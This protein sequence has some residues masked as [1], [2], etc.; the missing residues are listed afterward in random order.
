MFKLENT[1][2]LKN[3]LL[4]FGLST[5]LATSAVA[6]T[7]ESSVDGAVKYPIKDGK[8][9][10][11]YVNTQEVKNSAIGRT[12]TKR[13][14]TAWDVDAKPDGT[15]LPEF[16]MKHGEVVLGEDGKPKKAEGSVELGNELYDASVLCVMVILVQV[17]KVIQC[18]LVVLKSL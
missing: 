13:E 2:K 18:L 12:P 4:S 9:S 8:Y 5:L 1:K 14:I 10:S 7:K 3:T 16:D 15:G 6:A 17:E 11:Y